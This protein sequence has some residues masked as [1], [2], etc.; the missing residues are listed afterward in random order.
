MARQIWPGVTRTTES[1]DC[2][3]ESATAGVIVS[4]LAV[5]IGPVI[6]QWLG[7][8]V[9]D[10]TFTLYLAFGAYAVVSSATAPIFALFS[11]PGVA[12]FRAIVAIGAGIANHGLSALLIYPFG[13]AGPVVASLICLVAMVVMAPARRHV[14]GWTRS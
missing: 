10:T 11:G 12:H 2:A 7:R 4:A 3:F 13:V 6:G 5:A 8:G 1:A 14:T 9:I